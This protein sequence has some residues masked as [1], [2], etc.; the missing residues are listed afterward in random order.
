MRE[1]SVE[2]RVESTY[3]PRMAD[4]NG[5]ESDC[6]V[7]E[8]FGQQL[9]LNIEADA[10]W[11]CQKAVSSYFRCEFSTMDDPRVISINL[12]DKGLTGTLPS[13]IGDLTELQFLDISKNEL[14]IVLNGVHVDKDKYAGLEGLVGVT[15]LQYNNAVVDA[16]ITSVCYDR[17]YNFLIAVETNEATEMLYAFEQA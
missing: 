10:D 17:R 5:V 8:G 11:C 12:V 7:L 4:I 3:G 1:I 14:G 9:G 16:C 6:A 15:S 13:S 2:L